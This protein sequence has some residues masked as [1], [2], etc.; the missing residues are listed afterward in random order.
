ME[1]CATFQLRFIII[2]DRF[3]IWMEEYNQS[4]PSDQRSPKS[5][6]EIKQRYYQVCRLLINSRHPIKDTT[7]KDQIAS[8]SFDIVKEQSRLQNLSVL[9]NRTREQREREESLMIELKRWLQRQWDGKRDVV[10]K[11]I[12]HNAEATQQYTQR[13]SSLLKRKKMK[14]QDD[15]GLIE[16]VPIPTTGV[17]LASQRMPIVKS[18]ILS[19]FQVLCEEFG[20]ASVVPM[21][22]TTVMDTMEQVVSSLVSLLEVC[23]YKIGS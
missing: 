19:K 9:M 2:H 12:S 6:Q 18:S 1:L 22:T 10:Y 15:G 5:I 11:Y 4:T 16:I 23:I 21:S 8:F 20:I 7:M 13:S 14:K 17:R 3:S